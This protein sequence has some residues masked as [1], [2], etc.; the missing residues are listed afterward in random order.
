MIPLYHPIEVHLV[1]EMSIKEPNGEWAISYS[2]LINIFLAS[3]AVYLLAQ[4]LEFF[5]VLPSLH[6]L[7]AQRGYAPTY[8]R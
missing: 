2:R 1:N 3:Q 4:W 5:E 8:R 6:A 7:V